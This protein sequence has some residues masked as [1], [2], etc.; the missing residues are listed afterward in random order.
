MAGEDPNWG[1]VVMAIGK[2]GRKR[3]HAS[4]IQIKIGD[5]LVA[6][7]GKSS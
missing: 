2:S 3:I 7:Q 5:Y 6:E 4:K 1:R